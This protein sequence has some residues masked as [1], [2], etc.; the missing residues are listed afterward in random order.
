MIPAV[1]IATNIPSSLGLTASFS[2]ISDGR[3]KVVIYID[4]TRQKKDLGAARTVMASEISGSL[5]ELIGAENVK[6][7]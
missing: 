5:E 2:M 7:V 1:Q 3:D 6:T 4:S